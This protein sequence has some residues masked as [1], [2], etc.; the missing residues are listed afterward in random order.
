MGKPDMDTK[1]NEIVK[2][3][4]IHSLHSVKVVVWY[5]ECQA[6]ILHRFG[7]SELDEFQVL[8][9]VR[10]PKCLKRRKNDK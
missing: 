4:N 7:L 5:V 1:S 9:P 10:N 3:E 8:L 6:S 2:E